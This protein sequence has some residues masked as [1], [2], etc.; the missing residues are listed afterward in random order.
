MEFRKNIDL[1]KL[2][3]LVVDR[4]RNESGFKLTGYEFKF[5]FNR[6]WNCPINRININL[7]IFGE[8]YTHASFDEKYD[9]E[10]K[11]VDILFV[12]LRDDAG[13][14]NLKDGLIS[15]KRYSMEKRAEKLSN[16]IKDL[17]DQHFGQSNLNKLTTMVDE[18]Y[19]YGETYENGFPLMQY[20]VYNQS[21]LIRKYF[22]LGFYMRDFNEN[23]LFQ[24]IERLIKN[25]S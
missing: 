13:V 21:N 4:F 8:N 24:Q 16:K 7:L 10:E 12:H 20:Q 17:S 9:S 19:P 15:A 11:V 5:E 2:T 23:K 1:F 18:K 3:E 25:N 14:Q 22:D 6:D